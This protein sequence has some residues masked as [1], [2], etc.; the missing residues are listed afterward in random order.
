MKRLLPLV[1]LLLLAART[2]VVGQTAADS[3]GVFDSLLERYYAALMYEDDSVKFASY[4]GE[5]ERKSYCISHT[6]NN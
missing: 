2:P 4:L 1:L 5:R 6:I 3:S